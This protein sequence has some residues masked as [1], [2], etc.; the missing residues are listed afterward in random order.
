MHAGVVRYLCISI[1]CCTLQDPFVMLVFLAAA[2]S[3]FQ[4]SQ[5][6][7]T[8]SEI[9]NV[10]SVMPVSHRVWIPVG[11]WF[12]SGFINTL[13]IPD[14]AVRNEWA[15]FSLPSSLKISD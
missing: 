10:L 9:S 11:R 5:N 14:E 6:G 2:Q 12:S 7:W 1:N 3:P 8:A 4:F 13:R 15:D